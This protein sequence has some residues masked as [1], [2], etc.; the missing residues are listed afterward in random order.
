MR[1]RWRWASVIKVRIWAEV[2][3]GKFVACGVA[4]QRKKL[5]RYK[6]ADDFLDSGGYDTPHQHEQR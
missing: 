4:K 3:I 6:P 2:E 5:T 1:N